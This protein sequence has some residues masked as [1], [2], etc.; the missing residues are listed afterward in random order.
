MQQ[1]LG[2]PDLGILNLEAHRLALAIIK[3]T[4]DENCFKIAQKTTDRTLLS[5]KIGDRANFKNKEQA[6]QQTGPQMETW[7]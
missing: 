5:F 2:E 3:K 1:F 7:I 6:P 4:L